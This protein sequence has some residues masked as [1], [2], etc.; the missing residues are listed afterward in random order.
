MKNKQRTTGS[1]YATEDKQ[2]L[3]EIIY[4]YDFIFSETNFLKSILNINWDNYTPIHGHCI[5]I[6]SLT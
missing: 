2:K 4:T 1:K 5:I 6:D 3:I